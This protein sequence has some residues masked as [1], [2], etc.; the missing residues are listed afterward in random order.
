M[1]KHI[2]FEDTKEIAN[3]RVI[4]LVQFCG[5][6]IV[7]L[8]LFKEVRKF[9]QIGEGSHVDGAERVNAER[10]RIPAAHPATHEWFR[11]YKIPTG[12]PANHF[13]FDGQYKNAEF[14]HK[15]YIAVLVSFHTFPG[16]NTEKL[17]SGKF[18]WKRRRRIVLTE[19]NVEGA[20]HVASQDAWKKIVDSQ[21]AIGKPHDPPASLDRW[22]FI[23]G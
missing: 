8:L 9:I 2:V 16:G 6:T 21:P 12:K 23:K 3:T 13:G 19:T 11:V 15:E 4:A 20:A 18:I 14:A 1:A 10:C 17:K 7:D 22:H 5:V